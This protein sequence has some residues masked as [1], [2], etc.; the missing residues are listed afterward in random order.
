M[1]TLLARTEERAAAPIATNPA[2][3]KVFAVIRIS[4]G[5]IFLWAFVDKLFGLGLATAEKNAFIDGGSPTKGF[6]GNAVE[7]PFAE[8][9]RSFAGA[10][11]ADWLFMVGLAGIGLALM[12]GIGMRIATVSGVAL[13]VMMW[14]AVLP[15]ANNPFMDDHIIYALVLV[16]LYLVHAGETWGLGKAWGRTALVQRLPILK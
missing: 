7:G 1:T 5:W 8:F 4:L 13:L 6:L 3:Q 15:P 9:Y 10:A 2:V 16:A 14:T 11:W 12:L